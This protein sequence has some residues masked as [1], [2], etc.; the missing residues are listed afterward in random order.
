LPVLSPGPV[1]GGG[2]LRKHARFEGRSQGPR[3]SEQHSAIRAVLELGR[4]AL[5]ARD[6]SWAGHHGGRGSRRI[7]NMGLWQHGHWGAG[8][9]VGSTGGGDG[10]SSQ[11]RIRS[12]FALAAG[13]KQPR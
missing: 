8:V 10:T 13:L 9:G 3:P 2:S 4:G 6:W 5:P 1:A 11:A 12:N 7:R